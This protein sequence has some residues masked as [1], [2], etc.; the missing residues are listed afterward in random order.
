MLSRG[1]R[2]LLRARGLRVRPPPFSAHLKRS[3][4]EVLFPTFWSPSCAAGGVFSNAGG[5]ALLQSGAVGRSR[6]P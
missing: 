1:G 5:R 2:G 4:E 6:C 3:S